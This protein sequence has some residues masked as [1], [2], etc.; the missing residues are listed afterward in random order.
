MFFASVVWNG[1]FCKGWVPVFSATVGGCFLQGWT[2]FFALGM[3]LSATANG[4]F[5]K[6]QCFLRGYPCFLPWPQ[7]GGL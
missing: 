3:V 7:G 5:Y 4:V 1:I 2:V 6:G